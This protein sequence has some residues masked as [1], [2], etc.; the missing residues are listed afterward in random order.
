MAATALPSRRTAEVRSKPS[1]FRKLKALFF[2]WRRP[3]FS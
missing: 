2:R 1:A 3:T